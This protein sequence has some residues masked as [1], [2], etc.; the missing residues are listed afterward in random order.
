LQTQPEPHKLNALK[1]SLHPS[2]ER[3]LSLRII[4]CMRPP[5]QQHSVRR[6]V[7]GKNLCIGLMGAF[8]TLTTAFLSNS[9]ISFCLRHSLAEVHRG[10]PMDTST[11]LRISHFEGE[12]NY[13]YRSRV[14][15]S[16]DSC[17]SGW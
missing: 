9:L 6:L 4:A 5:S 13:E 7:R 12:N 14:H 15:R 16:L 1:D 3:L 17:F 2:S 10:F 8:T 11:F